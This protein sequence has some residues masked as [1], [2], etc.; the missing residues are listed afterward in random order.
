MKSIMFSEVEFMMMYYVFPPIFCPSDLND[1]GLYT[2][3][4]MVVLRT[5]QWSQYLCYLGEW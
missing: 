1:C 5:V 3:M 2:S 4:L